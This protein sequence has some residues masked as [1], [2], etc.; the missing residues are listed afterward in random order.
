M[1]VIDPPAVDLRR[2]SVHGSFVALLSQAI[3]FVLHLTSVVLL[4]RLV[5][6][7]D[8]GLFGI[9]IA[10]TGF[11]NLFRDLG[12][13]LAAIQSIE[14]SDR[15][16]ST[17]Y[18]VNAAVGGVLAVL[19]GIGAFLIGW[20]YR[21]P[22]LIEMVLVMACIFVIH[23]V[24][25]L[26]HA[27]L[28]RQ[29]RF[30]TLAFIDVSAMAVGVMAGIVFAWNGA[31]YWSLVLM[32]LTTS[33]SNG[34]ASWFFCRWKPGRPAPLIEIRPLLSFG[35]RVT[36]IG[37]LIYTTRNLDT[38]LIGWYWGMSELG[39]YDKAYQFLLLP[40]LQISIPLSGVALPMLCRLQSDVARYRAFYSR[41]LLLV[42]SLAMGLIAFVFIT[43]EKT[44]LVVLGAT[45]LPA[46]PMF[47]A[48]AP[49]AFVDPFYTTMSWFLLSL[50]QTRRM[51]RAV[52]VI[53]LT[54]VIS[55]GVGLPWGAVGVAGVFSFTRVL[56]LIPLIVY[57]CADSPLRWQ[58][59]LAILARPAATSLI[60]ALGLFVA[61]PLLAL[62]PFGEL[63]GL[64]I[65][66]LIFGVFYLCAWLIIPGGG[67][68]ARE[69]LDLIALLAPTSSARRDTVE[70]R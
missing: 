35:G 41:I 51:L 59:V 33:L 44:V 40:I 60:A 56:M 63:V 28:R 37:V 5:M 8:Y 62:F 67:L 50:G 49:A 36:L 66:G 19:A 47:R 42:A 39:F 13:N 31:G 46:V 21:E 3:K 15:Q 26:P 9:V 23:G 53:S 20:V 11:I 64:I 58:E 69:A 34:L 70:L 22:R 7:S 18:W 27:L 2:R 24:A 61:M 54:A 14:I 17:V 68:I 25:G 4:A 38:L 57:C 6:P 32:H 48:L 30:I 10:V 29:L 1:I 12:L 65:S 55:F 52:L 45:W 43:T 16:L